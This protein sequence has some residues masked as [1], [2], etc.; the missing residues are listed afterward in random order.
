L[1]VERAVDIIPQTCRGLHAAHEKGLIHRDIKPNNIIVLEDDSVKIIDFGMA[2]V[3]D[4]RS[5]TGLKG[6]LLYMAPEQVEMKP[7]SP[8]SDIFS[9][10]VVAFETLTRRRPFEGATDRDIAR[11]IVHHIPPP[12]SDFNPMVSPSVARVIHRRWRS[13][14][15]TG[16][17]ACAS[18][19]TPYSGLC[20]MNPLRCLTPRESGLGSC[21]R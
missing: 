10:G 17:Q 16:L 11:S 12:A 13:S 4:S 5:R 18:L 3:A 9:L 8:L 1:T 2:H 20:A 15:T 19:L 21:V 14:R 7:P 6:T